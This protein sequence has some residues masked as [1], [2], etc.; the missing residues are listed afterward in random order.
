[1]TEIDLY[2]LAKVLLAVSPLKSTAST[3][4]TVGLFLFFSLFFWALFYFSATTRCSRIILYIPCS[5][6][7]ISHF[8]QESQFLLLEVGRNQDLGAACV[9]LASGSSLLTEQGNLCI[10]THKPLHIRTSVS[11]SVCSHLYLWSTKR[12]PYLCLWLWELYL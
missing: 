1:M 4:P 10:Y 9:L 2:H 7:R 12:H 5:R 6:S 3:S 8:P 11:A